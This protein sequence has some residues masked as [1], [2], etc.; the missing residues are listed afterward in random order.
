L[1]KFPELVHI[2]HNIEMPVA[3]VLTS[4]EENG[5]KLDHQFLDQ[6]SVEFAET[7]QT[8]ENQATELAGEAFNVASPKQVGEVLFERLGL[9]GGKKTATG[10]YS[11]D[12]A[13]GIGC[14]AN[15]N[16][17]LKLTCRITQK[18]DF[19]KWDNTSSFRCV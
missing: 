16:Y 14:S 15:G 3:R 10:Q 4:M 19:S 9:K 17:Q 12:L 11:I 13:N 7:I 8:L 6:L 1:K 5:I 18:C 2:L